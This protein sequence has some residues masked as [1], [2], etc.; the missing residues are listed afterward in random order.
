MRKPFAGMDE[1]FTSQ[2]KSYVF[3]SLLATLTI[4]V[5]LFIFAMQHPVIIASIGATAFI[6]FA[7]PDSITAKPRNVVGGH[8]VGL[9][10]GFLCALI[11]LTSRGG[12]HAAGTRTWEPALLQIVIY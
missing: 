12:S 8:L 4:F 11:P 9:F 6:V 7:M 2:W 5:V 3:Q 1:E 10:C